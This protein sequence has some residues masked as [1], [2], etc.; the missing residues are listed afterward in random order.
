METL[1][2]TFSRG[3]PKVSYVK[4]IDVWMITCDTFVFASILE[5][6]MA[7]YFMRRITGDGKRRP[8]PTRRM[9]KNE[10]KMNQVEDEQMTSAPKPKLIHKIFGLHNYYYPIQG[11][12]YGL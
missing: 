7:Q 12:F 4:M 11:I 10:T 3:M 1:G 6:A 2:Q 5:F 8:H 9:M